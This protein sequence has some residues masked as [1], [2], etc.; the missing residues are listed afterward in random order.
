MVIVSIRLRCVY[1]DI[2]RAV[3]RRARRLPSGSPPA[4]E[5]GLSGGSSG[6]AAELQWRIAV[7]RFPQRVSHQ[8]ML[9]RQTA[10]G[11]R[12]GGVAGH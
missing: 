4:Y 1:Q 3:L 2:S 6:H 8:V 7:P 10:D 12:R 11:I 5:R 9:W